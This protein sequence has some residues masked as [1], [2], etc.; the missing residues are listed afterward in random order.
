MRRHGIRIFVTIAA[1]AAMSVP[2]ATL[3]A[4]AG[5]KPPAS[6]NAAWRHHLRFRAPTITKT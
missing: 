1:V 3:F 4:Q 5:A 6:Y 2:A